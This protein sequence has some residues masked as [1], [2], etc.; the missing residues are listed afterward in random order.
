[1]IRFFSSYA[2]LEKAGFSFFYLVPTRVKTIK[3]RRSSWVNK[4][5]WQEFGKSF[6]RTTAKPY[7]RQVWVVELA[8][9]PNLTQVL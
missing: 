4:K 9:D 7:F 6:C 8:Q 1:M 3:F 2:V 5:V